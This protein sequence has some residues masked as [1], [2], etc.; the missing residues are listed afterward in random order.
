MLEQALLR[1]LQD[2][3]PY[4][5]SQVCSLL[6]LDASTLLLQLQELEQKGILLKYDRQICQLLQK[7][8]L[9]DVQTILDKLPPSIYQQLSKVIILPSIESTNTYLLDYPTDKPIAC[10]AEYQTQGRGRRGKQ[11]L[12]PYASGICLS[13]KYRYSNPNIPLS[14]LSLA[15]S[16]AVAR[17]LYT[18]GISDVVVKWPNDIWWQERKLAGLLVETRLVNK[19]CYDIVVGIGLNVRIPYVDIEQAWI[20]LQTIL[21]QHVSRND[22]ASHLIEHILMTLQHYEQHGFHSYLADWPRFDFLQGK[23]IK[24]LTTSGTITGQACGIDEQGALLVKVGQKIKPFYSG[25]VSVSYD[26]T[27]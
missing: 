27:D 19:N 17:F 22:V 7:T 24:L 4:A 6:E 25:E 11:W 1:L 14:C 18:L 13:V 15:L 26:A 2:Q 5:L 3:Q 23:K 10:L 21:P 9:L 20:D 12:S 16:I 8:E